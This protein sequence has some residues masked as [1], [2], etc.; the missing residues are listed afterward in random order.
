[1]ASKDKAITELDAATSLTGAELL[2]VVQSGATVKASIDQVIDYARQANAIAS[3]SWDS[4][5]NTPAAIDGGPTAPVVTIVHEGMKRCVVNDSGVVVYYLSPTDSTKKADGTSANLDGSDGQVMV[6]VPAFYVR[7]Q[8]S[9][10]ITTWSISAFALP[11]YTIHP[12]FVKDGVEVSKRYIG[13]YDACVFDADASAY[14]SGTNL[15]DASS[16]INTGTDKLASVSGVYPMVGLNRGQFRTLAANRGSFWRQ[17]DF[18]LWSAIQLLYLVEYQSFY[19]QN[20]TGAGNTNGSYLGSSSSQ[21]DSPHTV[22]GASNARGNGS[23]NTTTGAGVSGKPG[24]SY[25]LYRG[26]ENL[27]GNCWTFV[28]GININVGAAGN[29]HVTNNR[30][31]FADDTSTNMTLLTN[32]AATSANYASAIAALDAYFIPTSVSGGSSSTYLTDYW[33]GSGSSNRVAFVGGDA[34]YGALAGAFCVYANDDS[35][36]RVRLIGARLAG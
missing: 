28:D 32:A 9:G 1:M 15:D 12:A 20:I 5:T 8:V 29:V 22:A 7:R 11:G 3:F 25:M 35:S 6:E 34:N 24:T 19:S 4:A 36:V 2:P 30:S 33:Y 16:L 14:I 21:N 13:A 10:T 18:T 23:T 31:H 27:Y 17:L 26:I